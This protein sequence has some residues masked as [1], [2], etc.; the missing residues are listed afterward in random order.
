[1]NRFLLILFIG[2]CLSINIK[3]PFN[4]NSTITYLGS[5][6]AHNWKGISR[7][8]KGGVICEKENCIVQ[9]IIPLESFDSGSAGRDSNMLFS[10]ESHK[11]PYVKY[12]SD[13]FLVTNIQE[14]VSS[15]KLSG[16]IE[17]HGITNNIITEINI[18]YQDSM[19]LGQAYFSISLDDYKIDKPQLL[20]AP[21]SDEVKLEC[22]LYFD[23][24]FN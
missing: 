6:P 2:V 10:T 18:D 17:F 15:F 7:E 22:N 3:V 12:Y 4:D 21:I 9:V 1:M 11:Y 23:N 16:Y 14:E 8:V 5:H 13:P 20:F 19:L 24:V